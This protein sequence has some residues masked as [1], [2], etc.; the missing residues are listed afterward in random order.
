MTMTNA[1]RLLSVLI[2]LCATATLFLIGKTAII[3]VLIVL[4]ALSAIMVVVEFVMRGQSRK[5]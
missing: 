4:C 2:L 5:T 1:H 3:P